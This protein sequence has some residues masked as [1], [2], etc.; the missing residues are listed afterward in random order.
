MVEANATLTKND[1]AAIFKS[2]TYEKVP[3]FDQM[4]KPAQKVDVVESLKESKGKAMSDNA[5]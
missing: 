5:K 4:G 3:S 2:V 1:I